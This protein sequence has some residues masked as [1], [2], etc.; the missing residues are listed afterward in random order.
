MATQNI[1]VSVDAVVF[2]YTSQEGLSILL[3]KRG[4]E[5]YRGVWALPGGLVHD[6]ESLEQ[7]VERELQEETG[8]SINYL[9]QLYSFG[10][11]KRD[12]RNRVVSIAYYGLV[13]PSAF[14]LRA[15]SDASEAAW[16]NT[17]A[18]PQLAFDHMSIITTAILR[19]RGKLLYEPIGF[20]LLEPKFPF[21]E[22]EKLYTT[23]LDQ[24]IDRRNFK[25]K[26]MK[27]GFIIETNEKQKLKGAGRPGNLYRFD[28][29]RYFQLKKSGVNFEL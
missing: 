5:P 15:D 28:E 26:V 8:V 13:K 1:K 2:G 3:V 29:K 22:L 16:F 19:L 6:D 11:P 18:L 23:V 25:K 17:K 14:N 10:S 4:I 27:Y 21:S 20:E 24:P 12:P 9:E 7:A